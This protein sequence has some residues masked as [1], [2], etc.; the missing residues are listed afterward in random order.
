MQQP[1]KAKICLEAASLGFPTIAVS[2]HL[3]ERWRPEKTHEFRWV[4]LRICQKSMEN[5][6]PVSL[7]KSGCISDHLFF[8]GGAGLT[9][10]C[11]VDVSL[12]SLEVFITR[13][14]DLHGNLPR[15]GIPWFL[16]KFHSVFASRLIGRTD[17]EKNEPG[18][19]CIFSS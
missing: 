8:L 6:W 1:K 12:A 13:I 3:R 10:Y 5:L 18:I 15:R 19:L 2:C 17:G 7:W 9:H 14:R 11:G 4:L 16:E